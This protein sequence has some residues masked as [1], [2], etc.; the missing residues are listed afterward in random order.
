MYKS[1]VYLDH[2]II[3]ANIELCCLPP[4]TPPVPYVFLWCVLPIPTERCGNC[5]SIIKCLS[6]QPSETKRAGKGEQTLLCVSWC[7]VNLCA[8]VLMCV[9]QC[10]ADREICSCQPQTRSSI[11][12]WTCYVQ[13]YE[14]RR[15]KKSNLICLCPESIFAYGYWIWIYQCAVAQKA[16]SD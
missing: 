9:C 13:Q 4:P 7:N 16:G 15:K 8:G 12:S 1:H 5:I 11:L 3:S 6:N 2:R 14:Q 10:P